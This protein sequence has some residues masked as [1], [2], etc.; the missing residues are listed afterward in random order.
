MTASMPANPTIKIVKNRMMI[1]E[2]METVM[3]T[4]MAIK[5]MVMETMM[6][7]SP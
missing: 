1:M 6:K 4:V 7:K 3:E 2:A 5:M